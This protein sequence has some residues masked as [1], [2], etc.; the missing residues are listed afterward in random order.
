MHK[1]NSPHTRLKVV[2][3]K[4]QLTNDNANKNTSGGWV[5]VASPEGHRINTNLAECP[6]SAAL[7]VMVA[8]VVVL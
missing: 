7:H 5:K 4:N 8:V 2:F 1:D 6:V 3:H